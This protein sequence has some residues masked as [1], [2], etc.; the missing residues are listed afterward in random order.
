MIS[1]SR[2]SVRRERTLKRQLALGAFRR[3]DIPDVADAESLQVTT[4]IASWQMRA[5]MRTK[6]R[7]E[8]LRFEIDTD[9][10][11]A[12]RII[13]QNYSD[14]RVKAAQEYLKQYPSPGQTGHCEPFWDDVF[15]KG[16]GGL[17]SDIKAL[18]DQCSGEKADFYESCLIAIEGLS[19]MIC[20]SAES[21]RVAMIDAPTE[22]KAELEII[23]ESC[24]HLVDRPPRSF[25]DAIQLMWFL[26]L[27]IMSGERVGLVGPGRIDRS[28]IRYYRPEERELALE[29]IEALY[30]LINDYCGSSLAFAVMA[31]GTDAEGRAYYNDLSYLSFEA[32]RRTG[33]TYPTVGLCWTKDIPDS[34]SMLAAD[35][36]ADG[37][38]TPAFFS[39]DVIVKGMKHYGVP[40]SEAHDYI[41]S[42]CVEITP[43]GSSNVWVA[44]PY[45]NLCGILLE[46]M[47]ASESRD[48]NSF[49]DSYFSLLGRKIKDAVADQ[50]RM[51]EER[52]LYGRKPLQSIF[53]LNCLERG[54]DIDDGGAKYNWVECSFVGLANL[55]DSFIAIHE[56]V[57]KER[58]ISIQ[59]LKKILESDFADSELWRQKLKHYPKYGNA[60]SSV[61][62]LVKLIASR[63][64]S[65]CAKWKMLPDNSH[66]VPGMFCWI[67][68]QLLGA[69]TG[70][71]PDGR[72]AGF[73][74]ADGAGPAQ[75]RELKGPTS[76]IRSV[77]SWDHSPFI[78]GMAYNMK[79]SSKIFK[80]PSERRKMLQLI[81]TFLQC[82]GFETQIN[83]LDRQTLLDAQK[84]PDA[85]RD[86]VVRIGGYT[87]YFTNLSHGMQEELI[88]RTEF[89]EA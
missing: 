87:D 21:V 3:H 75:G 40:E 85:Y 9:E 15:A 39:D 34:L 60:D 26:M 64:K 63:I 65:A 45:F 5:G 41:N 20:N 12:G 37:Y 74:F 53:T 22:R 73:A 81:E 38:A 16:I 52:R 88:T 68:H 2:A 77:T 78:G 46:H 6:A 44:S 50:N 31:G 42:T 49:V 4:H 29:L 70:A 33:L 80:N 27:G 36:I 79:F 30:L 11:L 35:L 67:Q 76:G 66:F 61:D 48:F 55:A 7:M 62:S 28:L 58:A 19:T 71:T 24:L 59:A 72:S 14:E 54:R 83:V 57:Y 86:L 56:A 89:T 47:D 82:G 23:L 32:I 51:R 17:S 1:N 84:N 8:A 25:R 10:M 43:R 69:Q 13:S 18:K